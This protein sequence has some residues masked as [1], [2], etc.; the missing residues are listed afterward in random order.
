MTKKAVSNK[1]QAQINQIK[2]HILSYLI[3]KH[4]NDVFEMNGIEMSKALGT[5]VLNISLNA[6]VDEKTNSSA[7][8][9]KAEVKNIH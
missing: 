5:F 7:P 2:D 4:C 6:K 3:R 8:Y 1:E 9:V